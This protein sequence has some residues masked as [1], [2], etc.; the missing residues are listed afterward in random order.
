MV[1]IICRQPNL[2]N[3]KLIDSIRRL[4]DLSHPESLISPELKKQRALEA[5][6]TYLDVSFARYPSEA[7]LWLQKKTQKAQCEPAKHFPELDSI[8]GPKGWKSYLAVSYEK[9]PVKTREWL[10]KKGIVLN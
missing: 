8:K 2:D 4:T 1:W 3:S 5:W 10:S 7:M 6:Q 9:D